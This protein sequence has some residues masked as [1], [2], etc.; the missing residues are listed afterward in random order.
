MLK[1][2]VWITL[3]S[4]VLISTAWPQPF[5]EEEDIFPLQPK[6]VHSSSIVE[7][8]NGDLLVCW[9]HGSGERTADDVVVQGSRLKKGST[10]WE[11]LFLMADTP[12]F[13][14]CNPILFVDKKERLRIFWIS[15]LA[16]R[17]EQSILK[18]RIATDYQQTGAPRWEWQDNLLLKPGNAFARTVEQGFKKHGEESVWAEFAPAY[19]DMIVKASKDMAKRQLGWMPRTHVT[20]LKS[21]R[22]LLPLYSDGY[23]LGLAAISDDHGDT[24]RASLPMVGPGLNQPSIVQKQDGTL[25]A[26]MRNEGIKP[27][28]VL[29]S[30]SV[31]EGETWSF[32]EF[33]DIPNPAASVEVIALHDGS[34]V[35]VYNDTERG[36]HSL[37]A[38]LS[39]DEGQTWQWKRHI[40]L[41]DPKEKS[42]SYPSVI[43]VQD[44]RIHITYSYA[45]GPERT[46]KHVVLNQE[47]IQQKPF[48][49]E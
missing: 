5:F 10:Q 11:D 26:Y 12:G 28:R 8:P 4:F 13:P 29:K 38:A 35:M 23:C 27:M 41:A 39:Q 34:W 47:W 37:A 30:I 43:Q 20:I 7:C 32:A 49:K 2:C 3:A 6:H 25:V 17:W 9:F 31:D 14:D 36:R 48:L 1:N 40:A 16:H 46:I 21:G 45:A 22:Y 24:W 15:V 42:F 18:Y 44:D 33:T 19:E